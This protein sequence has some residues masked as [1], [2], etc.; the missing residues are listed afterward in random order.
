[1]RRKP[2]AARAKRARTL[3]WRGRAVVGAIVVVGLVSAYFGWFRDSSLVAVDDVRVTGVESTDR[4]RIVTAL[5][6]AGEGMTTLHL[7]QDELRSA[8]SQFPTVASVSADASFPHG[9]TVA[10]TERRPAL[11]A[12]AGDQ[13]VPIASDGTLLTGVSAPDADKLPRLQVD[14]LPPSGRLEGHPLDEALVL[15][16]APK[17][18]APLIDRTTYSDEYGVVVTL[19]GHIPVRFGGGAGADAKW[20]AA[21]ALLADPELTSVGYLDVRVP[22]RPAIG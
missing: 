8:V 10:V 20:T 22:G 4:N 2:A 6:A 15:G 18:L 16:A 14:D 12:V 19:H 9:L 7:S 13:E 11:I 17:P 5:T 21:A 3:N 1:V